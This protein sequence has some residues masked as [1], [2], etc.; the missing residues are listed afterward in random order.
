MPTELKSIGEP[1]AWL[2]LG[3]RTIPIYVGMI[4]KPFMVGS[5][6]VEIVE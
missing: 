6:R 5:I 2:K 4:G 3:G 1:L